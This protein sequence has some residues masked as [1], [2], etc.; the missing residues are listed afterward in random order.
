MS[1]ITQRSRDCVPCKLISGGGLVG[2]GLY[3]AYHGRK[4]EGI[5]AKAMFTASFGR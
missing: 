4:F 3:I 1:I 2:S 5:G